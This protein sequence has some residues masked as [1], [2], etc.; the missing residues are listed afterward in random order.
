MILR[1]QFCEVLVLNMQ[2]EPEVTLLDQ[3]DK[4]QSNHL[5]VR[6]DQINCSE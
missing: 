1:G 6:G 3:Y 5:L 2:D 4:H